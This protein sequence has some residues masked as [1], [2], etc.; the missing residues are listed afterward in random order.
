MRLSDYPDDIQ[1]AVH[2]ASGYVESDGMPGGGHS[3][4]SI[5]VAI[6]EAIKQERIRCAEL[7]GKHYIY[8]PNRDGARETALA[9][10]EGKR[11]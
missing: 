10:A 1:E 4:E 7:A 11:A 5:E 8:T 6:A 3:W 2:A 9:I